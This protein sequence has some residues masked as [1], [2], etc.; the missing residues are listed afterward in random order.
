[1][2]ETK[3]NAHAEQGASTSRDL[4][5][6]SVLAKYVEGDCVKGSMIQM[7]ERLVWKLICQ[8]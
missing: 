1:M 3:L 4:Q 7:A 6:G 5:A 2:H 8:D